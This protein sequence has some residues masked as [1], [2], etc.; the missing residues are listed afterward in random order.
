MFSNI[1]S[2]FSVIIHTITLSF[3]EVLVKHKLVLFDIGHCIELTIYWYVLLLMLSFIHSLLLLLLIISFHISSRH[4]FWTHFPILIIN[5]RFWYS[6]TMI[7]LFALLFVRLIIKIA[8][9]IGIDPIL[10]SFLHE[11]KSWANDWLKIYMRTYDSLVAEYQFVG[12]ENSVSIVSYCKTWHRLFIHILAEWF[13]D[14]H[15]K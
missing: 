7:L 11:S 10:L 3:H 15:N 9:T 8:C 6:F 14:L 2:S 13:F 5:Q 12:C 4:C 1:Y